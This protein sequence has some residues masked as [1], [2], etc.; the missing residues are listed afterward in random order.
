MAKSRKAERRAL[1]Q[2]ELKLVERTRHPALKALPARDLNRL[3]ALVR[4]RRNRARDLA[5][6]Q[7]RRSRG[8]SRGG[9]LIVAKPDGGELRVTDTRAAGI[10]PEDL[11]FWP[12]HDELWTVTEHAPKRMLYGVPR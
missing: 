4:E 12:A 9:Q 2:G 8:K 7:R 6:R 5:N 11:S 3:I 10:G 1:S